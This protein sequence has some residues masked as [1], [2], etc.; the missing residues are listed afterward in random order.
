MTELLSLKNIGSKGLSTDIQPW[1]L[2]PEFI[3]HGN[4]F[5]IFAGAIESSGGSKIWSVS[6]VQFYPG[7]AFPVGSTSGNYWLIAGRDGVYSFDGLNWV[8]VSSTQ[9]YPSI[10][11]ND[12]LLWTGSM[13]GQIP[14]IS[15]PQGQPEYWAPQN[16]STLLQALPFDQ[17]NSWTDKGYSADVFRSH[18]NFMFA[19]SLHE[20]GIDFPDTFRW[21]HPADINGLPPTWDE[22]E[23]DF[24]AGKAALGGD[25][26]HIIDGHSLRDAF[27]IYSEGSID[28]LDFTA[29]EFVW[30]RRELSATVGL[31]SKNCIAEV[32]GVHFLLVDG[33]IIK[34]DGNTI[35]SIAHDR[36]R[37]LLSS[38]M[39]KDNYNRAFAV[40]NDLLKEIW[41]CVAEGS[42]PYP[43][44][45]FIY[46][47]Q[48]D[49]FTVRDLPPNTAAAGYG[50][51]SIPSDNWDGFNDVETWDT[52]TLPWGSISSSLLSDAIIGVDPTTG[53]LTL[54]DP[55]GAPDDDLDTVI[56]RVDFP[57]AG[58]K[59]VTTIT[60][61][62]PHI[63]GEGD[64]L[65]QFGSQDFPDAPVR[66]KPAVVFNPATQ[67][68]IDIRTTGELHA[69]RFSSIGKSHFTLSGFDV[70]FQLAGE[71]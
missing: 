36:I 31:L 38:S 37:K 66:W 14:I 27:C 6:P 22:T 40:K 28:I 47:W 25:G 45:A 2:P 21:S 24:L 44:V 4:N 46:N 42:E 41:F 5:R 49:S 1:D 8:N 55:R 35:T 56:E 12:E 18:R 63:R 48:D 60:R 29:D 20:G 30:R 65:I 62:Y 33:D 70:E 26:G 15:N 9:G 17:V 58:F 53:T 51:Q 57:L 52:Q 10:G 69:W 64:L 68:K 19:L 13:L 50:T 3:T 34:N 7:M 11:I 67:R 54:P 61:I 43:N 16:P 23:P 39:S 59:Q 71:R 32:K